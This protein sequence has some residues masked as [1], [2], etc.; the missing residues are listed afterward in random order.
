MTVPNFINPLDFNIIIPKVDEQKKKIL[1]PVKMMIAF[2]FQLINFE[3]I[4][5]LL[6]ANIYYIGNYNSIILYKLIH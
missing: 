6:N 2:D 5:F 3:N 4:K 1:L